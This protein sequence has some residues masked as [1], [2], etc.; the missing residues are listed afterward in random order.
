[1][2]RFEDW[3]PRLIAYLSECHRTPYQP[4]RHDCALF[5]AGAVHVMCGVDPAAPFRGRYRTIRGGLRVLRRAGYRDHVAMTAA[6]LPEIPVAMCRVGDVVVAD[7]ADGPALGVVQGER[8][9]VLTLRGIGTID[10]LQAK[11]AF[12]VGA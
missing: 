8:V 3:M 1:M 2:T 7:G 5:A 11:R 6:V 4:G 12:Q 10:L 9:Y